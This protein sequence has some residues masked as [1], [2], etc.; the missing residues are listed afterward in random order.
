MRVLQ[1]NAVNGIKSTGRAC[2]ELAD[3][4]NK[5]GNEGYIAYSGGPTYKKGYKIGTYI[6]IKL[7]GLFSR[8]FGLQGYFS[9]VS[10]KKLLNYIENLKPDVVHLGNLHGNYINLKLLLEYLA[11]KDIATV[12]TLHD[13][14]FYTG[15]CTHY[16]IDEC[17]KWQNSCGN[18]PRLKK[19]NSSWFFDC[20]RKMYNNK[21]EWFKRIPRLAITGVSDWI[22]N[23]ARN[24]YLSSAKILTRIY[25]WID[26][27]VFKPAKTEM[28]RDK[29]NLEN[30]FIIL[31]VASSWSN[32]K[33]L[34]KFIELSKALSKDMAIIL[35]GNIDKKVSLPKNIINIKETHNID[36][37][38]EYYSMA[39]VFVNLSLEESFGKVTAEALACG[40]PVVV[41][42]STANPEL[43]GDRCGYIV[44]K[45]SMSKIL[46]YILYIKNIGK[47][48]Y[49]EYCIEY[50][51]NNFNMEDRLH[52]YVE[53]YK[54][55]IAS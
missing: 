38:V 47:K 55:I 53:L 44:D 16:T 20:T 40:T 43:V 4:L 14:W 49:S 23:E 1:I 3:Y 18:C 52:D 37:L 7:H 42:N 35:V 36:E 25:N 50:A 32:N 27:D 6:Q 19:D 41:I 51:K 29:L 15:K 45:D 12:V 24:S 31:G 2:T 13:C 54:K 48:Y 10:T 26:L 9:M 8:V 28:L 22:T 33:G 21:K 39:D 5:N 30:K 46:E 11:Q 17:Y 34:H